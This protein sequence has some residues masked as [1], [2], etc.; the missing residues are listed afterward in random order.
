MVD[1]TGVYCILNTV[2]G[3]VYVGST[4][5]DLDERCKE[6]KRLLNSGKHF[7]RHLQFAWFKYG[8]EEVFMFIVLEVCRPDKCVEREQFHIDDTGACEDEYGYNLSPTAGSALGVKM[9]EETKKRMSERKNG[10]P[11]D[12]SVKQKISEALTGRDFSDEHKANLWVNRQGWRHSEESKKKTSDTL[13]SG[14]ASG[15]IKIGP[16]EG[17]RHSEESREK[18]SKSSKGKPKTPEHRAKIAAALRGKPKTPE[19][20]AKIAAAIQRRKG[21]RT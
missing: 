9:S 1:N 21:R 19:H 10:V 4:S 6:H 2:N 14:I 3:K 7:N 8:G 12:E 16:P 5:R 15:R 17:W 20:L 11:M 18:M 13:R